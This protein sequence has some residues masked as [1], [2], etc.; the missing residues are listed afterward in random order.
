MPHDAIKRCLARRKRRGQ[1]GQRHHRSVA[2]KVQAQ[3]KPGSRVSDRRA[4]RATKDRHENHVQRSTRPKDSERSEKLR[5]PRRRACPP[6]HM[7]SSGAPGSHLYCDTARILFS[8]DLASCN[9]CNRRDG[10]SGAKPAGGAIENSWRLR[11]AGRRARIR[12]GL[13]IFESTC[14]VS[15]VRQEVPC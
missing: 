7:A 4:D 2:I 9:Q 15:M 3:V 12:R 10:L 6:Q 13:R 11:N 1:A 5:R 14:G 8:F